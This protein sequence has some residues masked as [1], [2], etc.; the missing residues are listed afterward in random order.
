[1][2]LA[3]SR[4]NQGL[5][6]TLSSFILKPG[7]LCLKGYAFCLAKHRG[8]LRKEWTTCNVHLRK[9]SS[10]AQKRIELVG[11]NHHHPSLPVGRAAEH[12]AWTKTRVC[13]TNLSGNLRRSETT[14]Y[15]SAKGSTGMLAL[16]ASC[17]RY[18]Q[19]ISVCR[20]FLSFQAGCR[21]RLSMLN[22]QISWSL[23]AKKMQTEI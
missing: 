1:M 4:G 15:R 20:S 3:D 23:I 10:W 7:E 13:R 17:N 8:Q 14:C 5:G 18:E 11:I 21:R 12:I 19:T 9:P 16:H 22:F 2:D 6:T